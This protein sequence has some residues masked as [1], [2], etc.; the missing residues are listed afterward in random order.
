MKIVAVDIPYVE[1]SK[2]GLKAIK[3]ERLS[4]IVLIAGKNG[5]G[6]SRLIQLVKDFIIST[7]KQSDVISKSHDIVYF[8]QEIAKSNLEITRLDFELTKQNY[9]D[10]Q[11]EI[12]T[13]QV[14]DLKGKIEW[15]NTGIIDSKKIISSYKYLTFFPEKLDDGFIDFVPDSLDLQDS[16]TISNQQIDTYANQIYDIGTASISKAYPPHQVHYSIKF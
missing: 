13:K 6:K 1:T 2:V 3:M 7:P 16:Y 9:N 11:K 8:Q 10:A 14:N 12:L 5:S 4:N 15:S